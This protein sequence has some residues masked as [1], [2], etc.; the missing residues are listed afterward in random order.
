MS[1]CFGIQ[2]LDQAYLTGNISAIGMTIVCFP[3]CTMHT[4]IWVCAEILC[5]TFGSYVPYC[6]LPEMDFRE[7][8]V[9]F[10]A[11]DV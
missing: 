1:K 9:Y 10:Q 2:R 6:V 8:P 5:G 3:Q 7:V 11:W 4:F